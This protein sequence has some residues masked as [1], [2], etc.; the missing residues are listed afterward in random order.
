[1]TCLDKTKTDLILERAR[2]IIRDEVSSIQSLIPKI[3]EEFVRACELILKCPGRTIILGM[4]KSGHISKKIAA[5]LASTGTPSHYVHPSEASHGDLGMIMRNDIVLALSNSG[6]TDELLKIIPLI[7]HQQI[8]II[9]MTG[10]AQSTLAQQADIHL[11]VSV[12]REAGILGL[13]PTSSTT[14]ALVMGDALALT[15]LES[16]GFTSDDFAF[17]HPAGALGRQLLLTAYDLMQKDKHIPTV[18]SDATVSEALLEI[19]QKRLGMTAVLNEQGFPIGIFTDGDLRRNMDHGPDFLKTPIKEFM[20]IEYRSIT[21]ETPA[22]ETL[23]I[24]R[25]NKIT[26]LIVLDNHNKLVGILH[27]HDVLRAGVN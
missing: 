20:T 25:Q 5:T 14:T 6:E 8:K 19:T 16:R 10:N 17:F 12:E 3:G 23:V 13:A 9:A 4:G 26:S 7:K 2:N 18:P 22:S 15:L 27:M 11:D 21:P 24:M 1:M